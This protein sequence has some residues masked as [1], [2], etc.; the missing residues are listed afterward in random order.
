MKPVGDEIFSLLLSVVWTV[1]LNLTVSILFLPWQDLAIVMRDILEA[2]C[3]LH[4]AGIVHGSVSLDS[5]LVVKSKNHILR[6]IL[7]EY[8]CSRDMVSEMDCSHISRDCG[9]LESS[10]SSVALCEVIQP[11]RYETLRVSLL[12]IS[13]HLSFVHLP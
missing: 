11:I 8:D 12:L 10:Y 6:G 5:V 9:A 7:A 1:S 3:V 4:V 2:L 13:V